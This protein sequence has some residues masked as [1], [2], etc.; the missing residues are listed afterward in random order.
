[1]GF[2]IRI[3]RSV[4]L[5]NRKRAQHLREFEVEGVLITAPQHVVVVRVAIAGKVQDQG[6]LPWLA[7]RS[8]RILPSLTVQKREKPKG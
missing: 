8:Y 1:M 5:S 3:R 4:A 2:I 6:L 7:K